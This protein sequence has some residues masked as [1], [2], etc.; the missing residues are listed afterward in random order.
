[1]ELMVEEGP[2]CVDQSQ[3]ALEDLHEHTK[4]Y[5]LVEDE[6]D[7]QLEYA[8]HSNPFF[9]KITISRMK[10]VVCHCVFPHLIF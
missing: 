5:L 9:M 2:L 7:E 10:V 3:I 4:P 1:M 8:F 6:K